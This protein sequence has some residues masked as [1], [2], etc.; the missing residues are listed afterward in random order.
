MS[1][2][3]T[4]TS[5]NQITLP[6]KLVK[7]LNLKPGEKIVFSEENGKLVLT[8]AERLVEELAGSVPVPKKW[9]GKDI[10]EIIDLAKDEYFRKKYSKKIRR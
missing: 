7:K 9:Q 8:P 2:L 5:K 10:N 6:V 3:G 4:I 1:Q